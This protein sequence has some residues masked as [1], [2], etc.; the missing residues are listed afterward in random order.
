MLKEAHPWQGFVTHS[1]IERLRDALPAD[2]R[3]P[4]AFLY[5]SGWRV[6][7]MRSLEWRDIM[8]GSIRLRP[9]N[10]KN[11]EARVLPLTRELAAIIDRAR[12]RRIPEIPNVFHRDNGTP[13]GLFRKSWVTACRKAGLGAILVHDLRRSCIKNL[14]DAGV[15]EK[16][17][18]SISGHKTRSVF[19]RY[20]INDEQTLTRALEKVSDHLAG[21]PQ[22]SLTVVPL[23]RTA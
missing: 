9:E 7:E 11:D 5:Y 15:P 23:R 10:S 8:A 21:Q 2:L 22:S 17:A 19:D 1:E 3:D 16:T 14:V 12:A 6:G 4:I 13:I 18:M 20:Q